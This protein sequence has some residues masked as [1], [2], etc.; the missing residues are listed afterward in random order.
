MNSLFVHKAIS[1]DKGGRSFIDVFDPP[2][3][4][5]YFMNFFTN[6][7]TGGQN[8][9]GEDLEVNLECPMS[10]S[11]KLVRRTDD[12]LWTR[13]IMA[14]AGIAYPETLAFGYQIPYKYMVPEDAKIKIVGLSLKE[15]V[16]NVIQDEIVSY[17]NSLSERVTKVTLLA[18]F[19]MKYIELLLPATSRYD[20]Y[21]DM[22]MWYI[23]YHDIVVNY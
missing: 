20:T 13:I 17:L 15:G 18:Y 7:I 6:A 23:M 11:V 14:K 19:L 1:F 2:R 5:T 4:V 12:K 3:H 16:D 8:A 21:H 9:E 10:S 22:L